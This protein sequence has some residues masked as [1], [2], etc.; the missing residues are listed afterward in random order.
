M[1][2]K[3]NEWE[4]YEGLSEGSGRSEKLWLKNIETNE[5][6]LFKFTKTDKTTE[7][8][9]EKLS[10]ELANLLDLRCARVEIGEYD[11]KIGSMSYLIN[12]KSE[13]LIEGIY[14]IN[15]KYPSYN[16]ECMYDNSNK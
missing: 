6:G 15:K 16:P 8:I 5:I 3:Y 1:L 4:L 12:D 14:L 9:S 11:S 7:H 10:S 13:I 2:V